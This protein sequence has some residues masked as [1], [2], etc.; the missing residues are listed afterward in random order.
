MG[1]HRGENRGKE[2]E[3]E[4]RAYD[5]GSPGRGQ[6]V[7]EEEERGSHIERPESFDANPHHDG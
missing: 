1:T 7:Q 2:G 4:R 5:R 3:K 6:R